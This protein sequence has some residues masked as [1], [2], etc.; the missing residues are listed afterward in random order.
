MTGPPA[1]G[2]DEFFTADRTT[3]RSAA[4]EQPAGSYRDHLHDVEDP[5]LAQY[6]GQSYGDFSAE[7]TAPPF[8]QELLGAWERLYREPYRGVTADGHVLPGLYPRPGGGHGEPALRIAAERVL[9]VL[10]PGERDRYR[11][12]LDAREWRA[13]SNPE[14]MI[15]D[16]GLRLE[17]IDDAKVDAI[18][19]LVRAC[20]SPEGY[21]RVR[22]LMALNAFLGELV[23][24]PTIMNERSYFTALFGTPSDDTP[25]GWQLFGHHVAINFVVVA[26]RQVIAPVFLGAEPAVRDD[27]RPSVFAAR[28]EIAVRLAS[29]L[30]P[31]QRQ[32]AVVYESVL[33]PAMPADRL[34]P[35]DER[36]VA[37]AFRDNRVIPYEGVRAD[38][39]DDGQRR[40]LGA[41]VE[42][43]L[44]LLT[45]PQRRLTLAD[46]EAHVG[47]TYFAW[48]GATDGSTP[49]YFRVHSPVILAEHDHHAG[50]WLANQLP[51]RF[52]VHTTLRLPNGND[53]G[54]AYVTQQI[55]HPDPDSH[56]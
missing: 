31:S 41:I 12:D 20:L 47:E 6:R 38:Q 37:G 21:A 39:L 54:R 48:Y 33:D 14:F 42:D 9:A 32:E 15:H 19:G 49:F 56:S 11:Y 51:A 43:A 8:V 18:L 4:I 53:Y 27:G 26:G 22:E 46:Y 5:V 2:T 28:E 1:D 29:S 52:H 45:E 16:V 55:V 17:D 40:L 7:R 36:H 23:Q 30:T 10:D 50:V 13:W 24:L 34:H 3:G 44:L 25:W 35:A